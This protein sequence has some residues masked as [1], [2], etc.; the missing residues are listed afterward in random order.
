MV[1]VL[2]VLAAG[3]IRG[4]LE[5]KPDGLVALVAIVVAL[6]AVAGVVSLIPHLDS[7]GAAIG[8]GLGVNGVI[9]GITSAGREAIPGSS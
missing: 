3:A 5:I 8:Y 4:R 2:P 7:R 6:S 9:K 1:Y